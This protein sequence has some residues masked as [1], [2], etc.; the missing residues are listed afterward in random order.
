MPFDIILSSFSMRSDSTFFSSKDRRYFSSSSEAR[1]LS[2][3]FF[4]SPCQKPPSLPTSCPKPPYKPH[5][6]LA[7]GL[8]LPSS[9]RA[10][11]FVHLLVQVH[12]LLVLAQVHCHLLVLQSIVSEWTVHAPSASCFCSSFLAQPAPSSSSSNCLHPSTCSNS[13]LELTTCYLDLIP[14]ISA[15]SDISKEYKYLSM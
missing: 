10:A 5:H 11:S 8:V 9:D 6:L 13:G 1:Y 4:L 2:S 12:L 7:S 15:A 14:Y 3:F